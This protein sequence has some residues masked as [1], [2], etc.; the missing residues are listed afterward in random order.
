[1][2]SYSIAGWLLLPIPDVFDDAKANQTF[3]DKRQ[4]EEYLVKILTH[5][6]ARH[7]DD[8]SE[9]LDTFWTEQKECLQRYARVY[10]EVTRYS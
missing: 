4:Y 8:I 5:K 9:M 6:A 7:G 1:V 2:H 10:L 3:N